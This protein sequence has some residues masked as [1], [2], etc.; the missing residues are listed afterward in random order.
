MKK[1][2]ERDRLML[3]YCVGQ[4]AARTT[5]M[6]CVGVWLLAVGDPGAD[7]DVT[8]GALTKGLLSQPARKFETAGNLANV[9]MM[10]WRVEE[11]LGLP[12]VG[13]TADFDRVL[14]PTARADAKIWPWSSDFGD[15]ARELAVAEFAGRNAA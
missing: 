15:S 6:D 5:G 8:W 14:T 9:I 3:A 10:V 13:R 11:I 7:V 1:L 2:T 4:L 12:H